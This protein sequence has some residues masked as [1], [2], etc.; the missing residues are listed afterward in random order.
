MLKQLLI[1]VAAFAITATSA[2]AFT[3]IDWS[4]L[5]LDLSDSQVSALEQ[6]D[7]IRQTA[8]KEARSVLEAAGIDDTKMH[9]IQD[10][11]HAQRDAEHQAVEDAITNNDY[12]A[13][14]AAVTDG[15]FADAIISEAD[16][17]K[18]VEAHQLREAGDFEGADAIMTE[19]GIE[20][21]MGGPGGRHGGC[22]DFDGDDD[23]GPDQTQDTT[24]TNN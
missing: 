4:S 21:P 10:A 8:D 17:A 11:M 6:A 2:A 5:N 19:L 14:Q 18:L 23:H 20:K 13:F 1:P 12:A 16:F 24:T 22:G 3:G 7:Q 9:E 15:P